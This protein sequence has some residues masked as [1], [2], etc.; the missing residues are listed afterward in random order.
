MTDIKQDVL[1][2]G[3][4]PAGATTAIRL[5]ERGITPL[6]LE[7]EEFPR[8]HIGEAMV[9]EGGRMVR[10][11]GLEP[12]LT[13]KNHTIKQGVRVFGSRG[14]PDWW[15]PVMKRTEDM[16]L[17]P[18]YTYSVRRDEWDKIL[19][20]EA[21]ARGAELVKG[22]ALNPIMSDDESTL[23]GIRAS[24]DDGSEVDIHAEMTL[25]C[26]GQASFLANKK[27]TGPKYMGSYD[28]QIALFSRVD[29][30]ERDPGGEDR[31]QA[32]GNTHIFYQ[33]KYHWAWAI[34]IDE[35]VT[36]IGIVVPASTFRE[37]GLNQHDFICQQLRELNS[38]L[39]N[40]VPELNLIEPPHVINNYSFQVRKF[41]GPGYVCIGDAHR[42][43]D[44][45]FSF[46]LY[47]AMSEA[48]WVIP[49]VESWLDGVGRDSDNPFHE[50]MVRMETATDLIEDMID[51]FW[52]NPIAFALMT[53]NK[54]YEQI[55]DLFAG[56]IYEGMRFTDRSTLLDT[57][58][59]L[60][61]RERVYDDM[62][63][64]SIPIG[65][66]YHPERAPLWNS[67]LGGDIETT[68][69]WLA[70]SRV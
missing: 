23:I 61:N 28:K 14:N 32:P 9:A 18:S 5:L 44:P 37:S 13:P 46:G 38:G 55:L 15:V 1:V 26:T 51:T 2:V 56:R 60:L 21:L 52:E 63:E 20:D 62:G 45:I 47:L 8:Y 43:V 17:E 30:Y 36:S 59:R 67:T 16:S 42:F 27:V 4:G 19:L 6:I 39:S 57:F 48:T 66:R 3:G 40:R 70:E 35:E 54:F 25:D 12:K 69:K 22:R 34:P 24:L 50:Y 58:S 33:K 68:E 64:F 7:R 10:E 49:Q 31:T 11:M 41:A 29:N 65:S 53:H